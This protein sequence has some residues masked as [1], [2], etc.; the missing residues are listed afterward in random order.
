[1]TSINSLIQML[2]QLVYYPSKFD[3]NPETTEV[4]IQKDYPE[5]C[6]LRKR[7]KTPDYH[8]RATLS[9]EHIQQAFESITLVKKM[10]VL[11]IKTSIVF[12]NL[13]QK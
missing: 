5:L 4:I 12:M 6:L 1:M 9:R 11:K 2:E 13:N 3:L 7:T 8:T 10:K